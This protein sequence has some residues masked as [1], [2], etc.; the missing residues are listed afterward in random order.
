[1]A[2]VAAA[3]PTH[4]VFYYVGAAVDL[5]DPEFIILTDVRGGA[6]PRP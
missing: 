5:Y 4:S 2:S 3:V 6:L 1:M